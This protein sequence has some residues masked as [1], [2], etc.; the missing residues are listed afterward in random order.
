MA[1]CLLLI[2]LMP[3]AP[4][5]LALINTGLGRSRNAA[6]AM[7]GAVV[8][9]AAATLAYFAFGFAW[10]GYPGGP[11]YAW[12]IAGRSWH[13][14]GAGGFFLRGVEFDGG[15]A[16][17]AVLFGMFAAIFAAVIPLGSGGDRW[18]LGASCLSGALLA[19]WTFPL[20]AHWV[21]GGGWLAGLVDAG[22]AGAI[23]TVGGLTGLSIAWILGPRRGKYNREGMP[24]AFPGHNAVLVLLG[25]WLAWIGWI[26]VGAAGAVLFGSGGPAASGPVGA[27]V[28]VAIN[29]TL[30]AAAAALSAAAITRARFG[31]PDASLCANGWLAGLVAAAAGCAAM[32]PAG[33][34][35]A[36]A[37]GGVLA[38][39]AVEWLELYLSVDDP[40]GAVPVHALG[41]IWSLVAAALFGTGMAARQWLAQVA[42]IA[43][44]AGCILPMTYGLNR[45]LDRFYRQRVSKEAERQGIDLHELGTGAY[46]EF[47]SYGEDSWMR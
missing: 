16:S 30:S 39:F 38:V 24:M 19:G 35:L 2:L 8:V 37:V 43:T 46:P 20:F 31:K 21:W 5:G 34:V 29:T 33:A 12:T 23:H 13:W 17:L 10:Q 44:L 25:C 14:I 1:V 18:R 28:L 41:G 3:L 9:M 6:H 4:A 22:G 11:G 7:L 26:G 27:A 42:A 15:N 40:A 47:M 32:R 36:G 45:L